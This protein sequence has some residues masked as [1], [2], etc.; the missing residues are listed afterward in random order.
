VKAVSSIHHPVTAAEPVLLRQH[1]GLSDAE[2][3]RLRLAPERV[4][5]FSS[6]TN[7]YGPNPEVLSALGEAAISRYPDSTGLLAREALAAANGVE[8][9]RIV[10]GNGAAD[11]LWTLARCL[12]RPGQR[13]LIAAPT[14]A[15]F[16]AAARCQ[17]AYVDELYARPEAGFALDLEALSERARETAARVLYLCSP[18]TPTGSVVPAQWIA[19]W[20]EQHPELWVVLDQSF[21]SLSEC[22]AEASLRQPSNV[23]TVRSLTKDHGIPGVRVG[24]VLAAAE[25]CRTLEASRP[26]W[27]TS[28]FAQVAVGAAVR[29]GDFVV[30]SRERLLADRRALVGALA[31]M[32]I[33]TLPTRASF[34]VARVPDVA[35]L[36]SRLLERHAIVVRDCASFGLPGFMRLAARPAD[37]RERL[38]NALEAERHATPA[39]A[40][41]RNESSEPG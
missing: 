7:P 11:L 33:E 19:R 1:G 4:L 37:Q 27:S 29:S 17:G 26:A 8:A 34:L 35:G 22:W 3:R 6:S 28:A 12:L 32:G 2:L 20:A 40:A 14:F 21:L 25:L 38:L 39:R 23:A 18:N 36:R 41:R 9:D 30:E 13:A 16:P 15:E 24:Y 10:L 31:A 5:D